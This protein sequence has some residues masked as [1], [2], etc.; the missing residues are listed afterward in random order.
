MSQF[1]TI[2]R[3]HEDLTKLEAFKAAHPF[4]QADCPDEMR[5]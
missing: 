1:P 4:K 2:S 3:I 5:E